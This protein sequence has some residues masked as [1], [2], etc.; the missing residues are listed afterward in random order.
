M[1]VHRP[2]DENPECI[3]HDFPGFETSDLK[4]LQEVLS[5]MD[6]ESLASITTGDGVI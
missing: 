2:E 4:E 6:S 3:F 5:F 1:S